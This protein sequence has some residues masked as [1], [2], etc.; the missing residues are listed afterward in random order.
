MKGD[1]IQPEELMDEV[2]ELLELDTDSKYKDMTPLNDEGTAY[3]IDVSEEDAFLIWV[4]PYRKLGGEHMEP[5]TIA[6]GGDETKAVE[7]K[8]T[9]ESGLENVLRDAFNAGWHARVWSQE[10][11]REISFKTW[12]FKTWAKSVK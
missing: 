6:D 12:A 11:S 1:T 4:T 5:Q 10:V 7:V 3:I 9:P 8:E 2:L